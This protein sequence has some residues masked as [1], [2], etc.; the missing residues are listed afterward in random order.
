MKVLTRYLLRA[1]IGPF[2]FALVALTGVILINT[3][4]KELANLAGKGLPMRVVAEFFI[5]SLP[6]NIALTLPMSVLVSVLYTFSTL[7]SENEITAL[8]ASG[9]DLRRATLPLLGTAALIAGGM[10]WFNDQVLPTANYRW[11][12]LMTDVA[13]ARPLLALREQTINPIPTTTGVTPYYLEAEQIEPETGVLRRVAIYDVT[14]HQVSRT[15]TADSGR[16]AFNEERTDLLLRLYDGDMREVDFSEP[17]TFQVVAFR[18]QVMRMQGVSDRLRRT[19]DSEYRT[20]RDMTVGMMRNRID[21][22]AVELGNLR[23][24]R[25]EHEARLAAAV[26]AAL[27]ENP[28]SSSSLSRDPALDPASDPVPD[29]LATPAAPP[30]EFTGEETALSGPILSGA[31]QRLETALEVGSPE[32]QNRIRAET[33]LEENTALAG[34]I[35]SEAE[36]RLETAL[37]VGSP[38]QQNRIRAEAALE[39]N[40][41]LA[42]PILSEAEQRL[43]TA[44]EVGSPEQQNRIRA[45][46]ARYSEARLR[47]VEYQIRE[48][49]VEI[50]KKYSIAVATLVFVLIGIPIALRFPSGGIGM[51]IAVSLGIFGIYYVCLIGGETLGDEGYVPPVLAMWATNVVFGT[52]GLL[53]YW[54]L[55]REQGTPR[56]G[57][58]FE[59]PLWLRRRSLRHPEGRGQ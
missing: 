3:L 17:S 35:L 31:G 38:E 36:Q 13:Q 42:G 46:A 8:R 52:L 55:G 20:D 5:L 40:T 11:R 56:G 57:G 39:E 32:Q 48:F 29:S 50:Q 44:L 24:A 53:G 15:I 43:E 22:L 28:D 10:V 59:L 33:A 1:H 19:T 54:R 26:D 23:S 7:A 47:N 2:F 16:M 45:E 34:P 25:E 27:E 9:V 49:E 30:G 6:A 37:E 58:A 41:V 18:E 4:A 12:V 14:D 51:V 21:T